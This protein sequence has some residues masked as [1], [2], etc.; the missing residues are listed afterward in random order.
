LDI[1]EGTS[2]AQA[3]DSMRVHFRRQPLVEAALKAWTAE[4]LV[5]AMNQLAE[6]SLEARRQSTLAEALTHRVLLSLAV[7][8]RR[9]Q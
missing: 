2:V 6:V 8:A 7:S 4:R 9:K 1:E 3:L 5:R